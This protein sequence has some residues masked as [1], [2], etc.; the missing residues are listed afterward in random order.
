VLAAEGE[1]TPA[2]PDFDGL[3]LDLAALWH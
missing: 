3:A 2:H 1:A